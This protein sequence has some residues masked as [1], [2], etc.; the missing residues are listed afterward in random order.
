MKLSAQ[1]PGAARSFDGRGYPVSLAQLNTVILAGKGGDGGDR[2]CRE[3]CAG[4]EYCNTNSIWGGVCGTQERAL[5]L[6]TDCELYGRWGK[7]C[8]CCPL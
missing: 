3:V 1:A 5:Q 8:R 4:I 6:Q 2:R 7:I